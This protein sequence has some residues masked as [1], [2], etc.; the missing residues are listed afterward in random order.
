MELE[1][2][3]SPVGESVH[4]TCI[5]ACVSAAGLERDVVTDLAGFPQRRSKRALEKLLRCAGSPGDS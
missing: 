5:R 2:R 1:S 3:N 4:F